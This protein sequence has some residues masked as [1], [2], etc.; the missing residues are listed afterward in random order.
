MRSFAIAGLQLALSR[1]DNLAIIEDEIRAVKSRFPWLNMFLLSELTTFGPSPRFAQSLPGEAE[2][3]YCSLA[4]E[5]GVWIVPGSL[6]ETAGDEIFNTAPV[7]NPQGEVVARY[8]KIFPFLPYERGVSCGTDFV[9]FD[10]P[11]I[12]R[13]GLSICYDMW[14]PETTRTLAWLGAEVILHPSSTNT[15]DRDVEIAIARASAATN[16]CYVLDINVA[17]ELGMGRSCV[18]GPG[19]ELIHQAGVG[20]EIIAI[21][22]DLDRVRHVRERGWHGLGQPL[23]SFRDSQVVYPPYQ[24]GAAPSAA[25]AG[26]G[27]MALTAAVSGIDDD[28]EIAGEAGNDSGG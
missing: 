1:Q 7:I 12:G 26:L 10:V 4:R 22:I 15:I 3:R 20:R 27:P 11:G 8:R 2:Q 19:G 13:F 17:G 21:E 25:L 6:F 18:F 28:G 14:F 16:Q 5:C 9:V 23:K 24:P